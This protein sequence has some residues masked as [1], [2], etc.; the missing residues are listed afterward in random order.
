MF[1]QARVQFAVE[2]AQRAM[3]HQAQPARREPEPEEPPAGDG[4]YLDGGGDTDPSPRPASMEEHRE[5]L[6]QR[7]A[8][9]RSQ[10]GGVDTRELDREYAAPQ[11]GI[12][13]EEVAHIAGSVAEQV[14]NAVLQRYAAQQMPAPAPYP[15]VAPALPPSSGRFPF[16]PY[17]P[18]RYR[19]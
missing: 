8:Q 14:A 19:G 4:A 5:R 12:S 6:R 13:R 1:V 3:Q 2:N 10:P 9:L 18:T 15:P 16:A 17:Y 7:Q 11:G